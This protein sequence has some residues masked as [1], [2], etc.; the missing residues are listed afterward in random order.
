MKPEEARV[1]GREELSRDEMPQSPL[2]ADTVTPGKL[3]SVAWRSDIIPGEIQNQM[4]IGNPMNTA[5]KNTFTTLHSPFQ[6][7]NLLFLSKIAHFSPHFFL[8]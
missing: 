5:H 2:S 1:W 8:S 6:I 4:E 7:L 3:I